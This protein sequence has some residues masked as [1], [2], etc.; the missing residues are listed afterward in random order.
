MSRSRK[1]AILKDKPRNGKKASSY[2]RAVRSR[3]KT[4]IKSCKNYE[5]LEIPNP[6]TVVNDYDYCDYIIDYEH[7][8]KPT[9]WWTLVDI[10][11]YRT[12][13]RRK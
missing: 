12:K 2:W 13:Y 3:I 8:Y 11:E 4:A 7:D 9:R 5:E 6:K 1:K 10:L